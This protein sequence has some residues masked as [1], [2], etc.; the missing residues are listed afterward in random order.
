[1]KRLI[2]IA[3]AMLS[4]HS[5]YAEKLALVGAKIHTMSEQ[6]VIEKGSVLVSDGNIVSVIEGTEVPSEYRVVDVSGKV[7]S[8]GFIGAL[9]S[10]GLVEVSSSSGVVDASIETSPITKTG[11]ALDVSYGIN[12]DSSLFEITR[13]EGMTAAA[14][15]MMG[16][17]SCLTGRVLSFL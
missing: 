8:P 7:I 6:G 14:T 13:L 2:V 5:T 3:L 10:L 12:P 16:G 9:T 11:A 17:I 4:I 1:M 15:G